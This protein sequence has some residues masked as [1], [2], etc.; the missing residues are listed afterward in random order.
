MSFNPESSEYPEPLETVDINSFPLYRD[1]LHTTPVVTDGQKIQASVS[2]NNSRLKTQA[3]FKKIGPTHGR[4]IVDERLDSSVVYEIDGCPFGSRDI[5]GTTMENIVEKKH[6]RGIY[7]NGL[8]DQSSLQRILSATDFLL[9]LGIPTEHISKVS[10]LE[11]VVYRDKKYPID[12][13]RDVFLDDVRNSEIDFMSGE[14]LP[15][16]DKQARQQHAKFYDKV[17]KY[18]N[19]SQFVA[20]E[21]DL[22]VAERLSDLAS[23]NKQELELRMQKIFRWLNA[24]NP[25]NSW[26]SNSEE[27]MKIYFDIALPNYMG[28]YLASLH[29]HEVITRDSHSQNWSGVGTHYDSGT[30][31]GP[32]INQADGKPTDLDL[33]VNFKETIDVLT[34]LFGGDGVQ[35]YDCS[36]STALDIFVRSYLD[37]RFG[38]ILPDQRKSIE[39]TMR[40]GQF[41]ISLQIWERVW[42]SYE[43]YKSDCPTTLHKEL[44]SRVNV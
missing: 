17:E 40:S 13:W 4:S 10:E 22:Q 33:A 39:A 12:K 43:T 34:E 6:D 36:L 15:I 29:T 21:R 20:I 7:I 31:Y 41:P 19:T 23:L 28:W 3:G 18:V 9:S 1:E 37:I 26:K 14:R 30:M 44:K 16:T 35:R 38:E 32:E 5:K 42:S 8:A 27:S 2:R 24:V 25:D 11:E